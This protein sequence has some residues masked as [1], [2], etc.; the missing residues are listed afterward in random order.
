MIAGGEA[1]PV[2]AA[3]RFVDRLSGRGALRL[4]VELVNAYGPTEAVVSSTLEWV[5]RTW[6]AGPARA[7]ACPSGV[8]SAA[9]GPTWPTGASG[10]RRSARRESWCS[11]ARGWPAA[12][13]GG[14]R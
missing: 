4:E 6:A 8:R 13:W 9:T 5:A 12:T 7:A 1:M 11:A 10:R 14:R 3:A 2:S